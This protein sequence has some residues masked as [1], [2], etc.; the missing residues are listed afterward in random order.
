MKVE[1]TGTCN[2]VEWPPRGEVADVT[3]AIGSDMCA[4]GLAEPVVEE[5]RKATAR[6]AEKR[7]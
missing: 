6:K 4:S 2:G 5:P 7:A 1:L 3:D